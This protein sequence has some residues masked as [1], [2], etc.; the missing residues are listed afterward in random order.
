MNYNVQNYNQDIVANEVQL[1]TSQN[2]IIAYNYWESENNK[3]FALNNEYV[4]YSNCEREQFNFL[5]IINGD[6]LRLYKQDDKICFKADENSNVI[7]GNKDKIEIEVGRRYSRNIEFVDNINNVRKLDPRKFSFNTTYI[8]LNV[9][10]IV[11]KTFYNPKLF[12]SNQYLSNIGILEVNEF[13]LPSIPQKVKYGNCYQAN[14]SSTTNQ[15]INELTSTY[16]N[17]SKILNLPINTRNNIIIVNLRNLYIDAIPYDSLLV[18]Q[19]DEDNTKE[20]IV[21]RVLLPLFGNKNVIELT[22]ET[23]N[24]TSIEDIVT[25]KFI[26]VISYM[27]ETKEEEQKLI[28]AIDAILSGHFIDE[29]GNK[30]YVTAQIYVTIKEPHSFLLK[31]KNRLNVIKINPIEDMIKE[32][33]L[34]DKYELYSSIDS[35]LE[36]FCYFL[37]QEVNSNDC[38]YNQNYHNEFL[39]N[40]DSLKQSELLENDLVLDIDTIDNIINPSSRQ[41]HT[42]VN[43]ETGSGKTELL[44]TLILS[45][46][47][48]EDSSVIIFDPHGDMS[49]E[50]A[51]TVNE[52]RLVCID[53]EEYETYTTTINL[54]QV[55]DSSDDLYQI[56]RTIISLLK[57]ISND[58]NFSLAM[59]DVL[60][61]TIPVLL[62][63]KDSSFLELYRFMDDNNNKDLIALGKNH[64]DTLISDF[65]NN[66]FGKIDNSTKAGI[67]RRIR[68]IISNPVLRNFLNGKN[69]LNL[70]KLMNTSNKVIIFRIP[71][72][73]LKDSHIFVSRLLL[74]YIQNI[75][76]KRA[77]MP[78]NIRPKTNLYIDEFQNFIT[79]S[80]KEILTESRKYGLYL[81]FANQ[82]VTQVTNASL[83]DIIL[84]NTNVKILGKS[85]RKTVDEFEKAMDT[86]LDGAKNLATGEFFI[87]SGNSKA[88]KI[89]NSDK[90]L[91]NKLNVDNETWEI[92]L[93]RQIDKY[94]RPTKE[95]NKDELINKAIDEFIEAIKSKNI[96]Y[97]SSIKDIDSEIYDEIIYNFNDDAGYIYQPEL[98]KYFNSIFKETIFMSNDKLLDSLKNKDELFKQNTSSNP[99]RKSKKRYKLF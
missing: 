93:Q 45:D 59:V 11:T 34:K 90:Y 72:Y 82:T 81:T 80:I 43:G 20:L 31:Y 22:K 37:K 78:D 2:N 19:G 55:D 98:Y 54:F 61:N 66:S 97:F 75:V 94:Y 24:N 21:K 63:K 15:V 38:I 85:N 49:Y 87:K 88:I 69:T 33:N 62:E 71:K 57:E 83:K 96:D 48:K 86:K 51:K 9:L 12:I 56:Q 29:N 13:K 44:K 68:T 26:V 41:T 92:V 50:L 65:F 8:A 95:P 39:N 40:L 16:I 58:E 70:E 84:S 14:N 99:T 6:M 67:A 91:S 76:M 60:E 4:K 53:F 36:E 25:R 28:S 77:K 17:T 35:D 32:L 42:L 89:K 5:N 79:P 52:D 73:I 47:K 27:P 46:I 64:S 23:L 7:R 10:P 30:T 74:A 18:L 1:A 3:N